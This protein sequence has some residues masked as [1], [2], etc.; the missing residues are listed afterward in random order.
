MH[1]FLLFNDWM[2]GEFN[3]RTQVPLPAEVM[4]R[5]K[6]QSLIHNGFS[7]GLEKLGEAGTEGVQTELQQLHDKGVMEPENKED[8]IHQQ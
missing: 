6:L 5:V 1:L 3:H 8:L 7:S 4:A 2:P